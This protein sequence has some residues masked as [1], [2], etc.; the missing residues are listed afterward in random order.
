[1]SKLVIVIGILAA[2]AVLFVAIASCDDQQ[3]VPDSSSQSLLRR[4]LESIGSDVQDIEQKLSSILGRLDNQIE[5]TRTGQL[6]S[7][8]VRDAGSEARR[9]LNYLG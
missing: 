3:Q 6:V 4:T 8:S 7:Q 1:M 2:L 9:L 5:S